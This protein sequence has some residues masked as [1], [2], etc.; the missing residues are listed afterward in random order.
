MFKYTT[1][2]DYIVKEAK[3]EKTI[4]GFSANKLET[5]CLKNGCPKNTFCKKINENLSVCLP[6]QPRG[7]HCESKWQCRDQMCVNNR[8]Q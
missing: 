5:N 3:Q 2:G 7:G 6:L 8:C 1:Q 4:E